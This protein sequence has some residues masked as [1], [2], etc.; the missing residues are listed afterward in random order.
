MFIISIGNLTLQ[1][2]ATRE[3]MYKRLVSFHEMEQQWIY[4][5]NG[6]DILNIWIYMV[7]M[8]WIYN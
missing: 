3:G 6:L 1:K 7:S 5:S 8:D 2:R 4:C